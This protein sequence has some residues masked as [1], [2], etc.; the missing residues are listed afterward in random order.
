MPFDQHTDPELPLP[1]HVPEDLT[2]RYGASA[3]RTV[4]RSHSRAYPVFRGVARGGGAARALVHNSDLWLTTLTVFAWSIVAA[5]AIG[6]VV[7]A[8]LLVP[9]AA[10]F[11]ILPVGL[12]LA[13]S[14]GAAT[15]MVRRRE[16]DSEPADL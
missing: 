3:R 8:V 4:R 16:R 11:V 6:A 2:A 14:F 7:Y 12:L 10:L 9:R 1:D 13:L 5:G 15:R